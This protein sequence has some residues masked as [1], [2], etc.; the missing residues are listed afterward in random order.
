MQIT[1]HRGQKTD[2]S[3]PK[4]ETRNPK[5]N[6]FTLIET[7]ITLVVL[8]IA[9]VGVLS[10]F[11]VGIT[12]SANPGLV[13]QATHLASEKMDEAIALKKSGGF[14]AVTTVNPGLPAFSAPFDV[15][16]WTR[17]VHCVTAADLNTPTGAPP[18]AS[19][20]A[21][22]TVTVTHPVIGSV[23]TDTLIT[24]Y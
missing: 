22:V 24:N 16:D 4:S 11:T 10:V 12:G 18:C 21:H 2:E 1:E 23:R 15:F 20:Y 9:A 19:G 8:S 17:T 5:W 6:G 7:V 3:N 14:N 13:S